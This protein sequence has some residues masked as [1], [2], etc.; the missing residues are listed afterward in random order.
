MSGGCTIRQMTDA[1]LAAWAEMRCALWPEDSEAAH[2]AAIAKLLGRGN[3]WGLVAETEAGTAVGFAEVAL[4]PY[5]NGCES[6]PVPFLEGIWVREAF[7]RRGVAARL[8]AHIERFLALH[9]YREIGSDTP[10]DN[11]SS[12]A[13]H[14]AWGFS[15][16]ERVVYF[17]K[18]IDP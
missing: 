7:R 4:R 9:G 8:L 14:R 12:Q 1:D 3:A 17:R 11:V 18:V 5:A 2:R 13:A 6:E 15:E 10:L 16:T